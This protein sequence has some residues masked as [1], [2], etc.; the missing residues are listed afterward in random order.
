MNTS[1]TCAKG[2]KKKKMGGFSASESNS[3]EAHNVSEPKMMARQTPGNY[4][5]RCKM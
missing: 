2:K 5:D 1:V 4:I 3:G